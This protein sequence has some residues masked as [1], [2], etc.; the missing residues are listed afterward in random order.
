MRK[1]RRVLTLT[2]L[3]VLTRTRAQICKREKRNH[4]FKLRPDFSRFTFPQQKMNI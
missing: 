4:L 3:G 2:A 1:V